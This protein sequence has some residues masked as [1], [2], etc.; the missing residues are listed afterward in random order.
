MRILAIRGANIASLESFDVDFRQEPLA[1]AG[2]FAI[3]GPTGSGK[4]SL[5]DAMCLA[6]FHKAPRLDGVSGLEAKLASGFGEIGQDDIRNL[7]R[8]GASTGFAEAEFLGVDG[9]GYRARWG[10]RAGKRSN[11]AAQEEVSLVRLSD[12]QVLENKKTDCRDRI[13]SLVGLTYEQFSRTVLLAQGRFAEFLRSREGERA[14]LL[15]KLTGTDIYSRISKAI[16]DRK[17]AE[18]ARRKEIESRLQGIAQLPAEERSARE[19]EFARIERI[20]PELVEREAASRA[21]RE[22]VAKWTESVVESEA[23]GRA[24]ETARPGAET[25]TL[26]LGRAKRDQEDFQAWMVRRESEIREAMLLDS[27]IEQSRSRE[28]EAE[29]RHVDVSRGLDALRAER[30]GVETRMQAREATLAEIGRTLETRARLGPVAEDWQQC[31]TLLEL[32]AKSRDESA[33]QSAKIEDSRREVERRAPEEARLSREVALLEAALENATFE[34]LDAARRVAQ[35]GVDAWQSARELLELESG[36]RSML[37]R[38][39]DLEQ[40][41]ASGR[42]RVA[43]LEQGLAVVRRMLEAT[44]L[45]AS[46]DVDSLRASL[47]EG[48]PC[49]VCG[50]DRHIYGADDNQRFHELV[51][52]QAGMVAE[53]E[54]DW[55]SASNALA[56]MEAESVQVARDLARIAADRRAKEE[57]VGSIRQ[58]IE[59]ISVDDRAAFVAG[60]LDAA[61]ASFAAAEARLREFARL[62]ELR[63]EWNDQRRALDADATRLRQAEQ[64]LERADGEVR[65]HAAKL[66]E[67]FGSDLWRSKWESGPSEYLATLERQVLDY[68]AKLQERNDLEVG[69]GKDRVLLESLG[70]QIE[71]KEAE[72]GEV[73]REWDALREATAE[74]NRVRAGMLEGGSVAQA[75]EDATRR[76]KEIAAE[77]EIRQKE[78]D[79]LA[80]EIQR[81]EGAARRNATER[82]GLGARVVQDAPAVAGL[83]DA[84]WGACIVEGLPDPVRVAALADAAARVCE[85]RAMECRNDLVRI[86]T[87][88][89]IDDR[90]REQVGDL[91]TRLEAQAAVAARWGNLSAAIG[92]ADGKAFR[93]IS[94]QYT[95]EALLAEANRELSIITPR[96]SLRMLGESMHFGV[97]DHDSFGELRPVHTLS[98]G[99][100]FIV[101]LSLALGLSRMAGGDL[102]VE[103][104]FID[105]G[106][107]TLDSDALRCV[108]AALSSL[109]SQG[110]KVGLITHVE[111]MKEQIP[112]RIE[113][114]KMGQGAS[115]V[116]VRG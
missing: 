20:L 103:S 34:S 22:T 49:P 88:L 39:R 74:S 66:D 70:P 29:R 89:S 98:G 51:R 80:A 83:A 94:Q 52:E 90:A 18:E 26:A 46:K 45:A 82:A 23:I 107:G 13:C 30:S 61:K 77:V 105:E 111:E 53:A 79:A 10:Y 85:A 12:A 43:I 102:A 95:L 87:E 108:M 3:T 64:E 17:V 32:C 56:A 9:V 73:R 63:R 40:E 54:A 100:S 44:R 24:L 116:E 72:L 101:S 113:V 93:T 104:L 16:Y 71:A 65:L 50:S 97:V 28:K 81:L 25:A 11:A 19:A 115:R 14:E 114:V 60:R 59:P 7:I 96:Y 78:A 84:D 92:S 67:K 55:K 57:L 1:S 109:H 33:R 62:G 6:L 91:A 15:E 5:L 27:R 110:R 21:F 112:V 41:I 68:R 86:R 75:Q 36:E 47:V 37:A 31:R 99:E 76:A 106:F 8:R 2:I 48:Q 38:N 58:E 69:Q 42:E 35:I 4:S